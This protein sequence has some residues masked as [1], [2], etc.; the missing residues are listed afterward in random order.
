MEGKYQKIKKI[1][2]KELTGADAAHDINH[3]MRVYYTCLRLTR[4][5]KDIDLDTLKMA[6]LLH[7]ITRVKE[8]K[9]VTGEVCHARL[10]A[11]RAEKILKSLKYSQEKIDKITHCVLAHRF[12]TG[13]RPETK[14]A[15]ILFD[16]DKLDVL[17]AMGIARSFIIAGWYNEDVFRDTDIKKYIQEN[18]GGKISGRIQDVTKHSP[19]IEYETKFKHILKRLHTKKAKKIAKERSAYVKLFFSRL[20]KEIKGEI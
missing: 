1:V 16:A 9:D 5:E 17:G 13:V 11:K 10:S 18:L 14:E 12:R 20:K 2:E 15:K 6:A 4:G 8:D 19:F 7:D 3:V